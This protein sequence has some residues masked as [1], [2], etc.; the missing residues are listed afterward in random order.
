VSWI[1]IWTKDGL[2][3]LLIE[4]QGAGHGA[5][6][7]MGRGRNAKDHSSALLTVVALAGCVSQSAHAPASPGIEW[8]RKDGQRM[9]GN[10]ALLEKGITDKATCNSIALHGDAFDFNAFS[11]CMDH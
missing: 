4:I 7:T 5:S 2:S 8:A 6:A 10:P 3:I 9:S 1:L 11:A